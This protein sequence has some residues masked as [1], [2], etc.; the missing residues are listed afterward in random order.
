MGVDSCSAHTPG[1]SVGSEVLMTPTC[2]LAPNLSR[3][4]DLINVMIKVGKARL[5]LR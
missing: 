5:A 4:P 3:E 1:A 2:V